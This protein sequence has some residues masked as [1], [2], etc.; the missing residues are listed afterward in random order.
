MH[1]GLESVMIEGRVGENGKR[2]DSDLEREKS[3]FVIKLQGK[4]TLA[5]NFWIGLD[6][7]KEEREKGRRCC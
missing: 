3:N 5:N 2:G 4:G 1:F 6:W 7:I